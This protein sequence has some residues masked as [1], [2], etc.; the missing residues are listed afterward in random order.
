MLLVKSE[1][2]L[3]YYPSSNDIHSFKHTHAR[4]HAHNTHTYIHTR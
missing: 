3:D 4:M 2:I 1:G